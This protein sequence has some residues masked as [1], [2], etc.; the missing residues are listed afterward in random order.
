MEESRGMI[1]AK[2][3]SGYRTKK[4][5]AIETLD[6]FLQI[7]EVLLKDYPE[8]FQEIESHINKKIDE[9]LVYEES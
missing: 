2:T 8:I 6:L 4:Q 1:M 3:K 5:L 9:I 7:G